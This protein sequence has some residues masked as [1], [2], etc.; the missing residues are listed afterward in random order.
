MAMMPGAT[1]RLLSNQARQGRMKSYQGVCLHTM[2]GSLAGTDGMFQKD[3]TVGTESHFGVGEH[4]EIY[5]WVDTAYTADANY[6]GSAHVIS[7]ET[8]DY[9]GSFGRWNTSGDNVPYWNAAQIVSI[10]KIIAWACKTH[11]IPIRMMSNSRDVGIGYHAMGV[12][13][14]ELPNKYKGTRYQWS[15]YAGKVCP[16]KKR[17]S[18]VPEI[19]KLAQGS[20]TTPAKPKEGIF[21]MSKYSGGRIYRAVQHLVKNKW[22]SLYVGKGAMSILTCDGSPYLAQVYLTVTGL[23]PDET[24][25]VRFI[26]ASYKSGTTTKNNG[27]YAKQEQHGSAGGTYISHTQIGKTGKG[28]NGRSNRLRVQVWTD[29]KTA[30]ITS[31][32]TKFMK[33]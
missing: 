30:K 16:G 9:G 23:K 3:G 25:Q 31:I 24:I 2:V 7:I 6:L 15:K 19:V 10:V 21:G 18:Q 14:N 1:N 5:Q 28:K 12:P 32:Q 22:R 26:T 20:P 17:I 29:S 11:D 8:A 13:G 27:Y 4:G 33:G